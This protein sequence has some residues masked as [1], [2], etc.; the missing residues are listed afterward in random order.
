MGVVAEMADRVIVMRHGPHGGG[1]ARSP[2]SS[3][4]RRP[5]TRASCWP[6][7]RASAAAPGRQATPRRG[8]AVR[9]AAAVAEVRDLD[10]RFDLQRRLLRPGRPPRPCRRRRSASRS[11]PNETLALVG[12]SG[13]GKSTTAKALAGLVPYSGDIVDRRPQPRRARPR[14]A[15]GGAPRRADD[16]PGPLRLARPAHARRRPRRRAAARP[17]HRL[18]AG[19]RA[20]ASPRCSSASACRPTQMARYPHEFSGGQRQRICIARALALAAEAHHRRRER[21]GARRVGAGARAG[22]AAGTAARVRRRLSVH[23]ARHGGGREHLRPRR[24]DVSRPDRRDGH[25]RPGLRQSAPSLYAAA[26]R[27]GAGAGS[28]A[29]GARI[30]RGSTARSRA[31]CAG[32]ATRRDGCCFGISA[33]AI[34]SLPDFLPWRASG[35]RN[36]LKK[37]TGSPL[38]REHATRTAGHFPGQARPRCPPNGGRRRPC[39]RSRCWCPATMR[40]G[41]SRASSA[42]SA[43]ASRTP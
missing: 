21:V 20:S 27:G 3:R 30:S 25:A 39:R 24:G 19:A 31:R 2:T 37:F 4:A 16:L 36:A 6:R 41:R 17:R 32:P 8:R 9:R 18:A 12:E 10:V 35:R 43:R 15:Q 42:P 5:T 38:R 40:K 26:D 28:G 14:R 7:C 22:A 33:T 13:C 29:A 34:S 23:L 11:P 1:R